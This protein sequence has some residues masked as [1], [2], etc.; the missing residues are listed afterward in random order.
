MPE[1]LVT[2]VYFSHAL[3]PFDDAALLALLQIS[4]RNNER[5]GITGVLLYH[6]GNFAQAL[7]GP[8]L[9]VEEAFKRISADPRHDGIIATA[10]LPTGSRQFADWSMGFLPATELPEASR[11]RFAAVLKGQPGAAEDLDSIAASMLKTFR[12]GLPRMR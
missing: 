9:A 11:R 10:V 4:R 12:D 7:E 1:D 6:D 3:E 2:V 8:R 5:S